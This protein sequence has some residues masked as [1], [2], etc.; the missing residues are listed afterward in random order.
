MDSE[1]RLKRP[2]PELEKDAFS[3]GY[4]KW[5]NLLEFFLRIEYIVFP[6]LVIFELF[7]EK[8][9]YFDKFIEWLG[10]NRQR[11]KIEN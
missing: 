3:I 9:V 2:L 5:L 11:N 6:L 1:M 7:E 10:K 4:R 8:S